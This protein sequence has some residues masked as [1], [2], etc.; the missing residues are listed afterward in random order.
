MNLNM[1]IQDMI[2]IKE[3][4][5]SENNYGHSDLDIQN[6]MPKSTNLTNSDGII[7]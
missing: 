6:N 1:R 2:K 4:W 5:L 7:N 3:N